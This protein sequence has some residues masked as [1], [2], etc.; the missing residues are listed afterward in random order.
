MMGP[1]DPR[2]GN[3]VRSDNNA[4]MAFH[5]H[6]ALGYALEE[7]KKVTG[8]GMPAYSGFG[9]VFGGGQGQPQQGDGWQGSPQWGGPGGSQQVGPDHGS[10]SPGQF[11]HQM[12]GGGGGSY[13]QA[14]QMANRLQQMAMDG[15]GDRP[16]S[17]AR[18]GPFGGGYSD[19]P[20]GMAT[21]GGGGQK[22][23]MNSQGGNRGKKNKGGWAYGMHR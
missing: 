16:S 23:Q 8:R 7:Y 9:D 10:M 22:R 21:S 20:G 1:A 13:Q 15:D 2:I 12:G 11:G 14:N 19:G 17:G 18:R 3:I 5:I 6:K 4:Q